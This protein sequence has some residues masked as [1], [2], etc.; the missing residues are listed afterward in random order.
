MTQLDGNSGQQMLGSSIDR[1]R[2]PASA[3]RRR[4]A[5][6]NLA[7][8]PMD[9]PGLTSPSESE[10]SSRM[11]LDTKISDPF[12]ES[13]ET[14]G[15]PH[16]LGHYRQKSSAVVKLEATIREEPST[17]TLRPARNTSDSPGRLEP[18]VVSWDAEEES[19]GVQVFK[20]WLE[21]QR[22]AGDECRRVRDDWVDSEESKN[23]VAGQSPAFSGIVDPLTGLEGFRL[24]MTN[25]EIAD[26]LAKSSEIYK[27]LDQLPIGRYVHHRK[28]SLCDA[29]LL[30]SPYGLPLPKPPQP[31][32][33]KTSL[34]TKFERTNSSTSS[35]ISFGGE[36]PPLSAPPAPPSAVFAQFARERPTNPPPQLVPMALS[37]PFKL[38]NLVALVSVEESE[39]VETDGK[40]VDKRPHVSP[41]ARRQALGWGRRRNSDG[42]TKMKKKVRMFEGV[43]LATAIFQ[44]VN[45]PRSIAAW[46]SSAAVRSSNAVQDRENAVVTMYIDYRI[47]RTS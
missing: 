15:R 35:N 30:T 1:P 2:K 46:K 21:W 26:F 18:E 47:S 28:S 29:R 43:P 13:S 8:L 37:S 32:K 11:S 33:P 5:K 10:T 4:P 17:A 40:A 34:I 31:N 45:I 20:S 25:E 39:Q 24:P 42:P 3:H 9:T 12:S 6:L 7:Y 16:G 27:P 23:A 14:H 44:D 38:P 36:D 22:E 19:G 41:D